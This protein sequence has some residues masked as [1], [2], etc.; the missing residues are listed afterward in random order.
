M[1]RNGYDVFLFC[2]QFPVTPE[3]IPLK[4]KGKNKTMTLINDGEIN[5]LK[6][7]GLTDVDLEFLLP[8]QPGYPFAVYP[9]GFK[10]PDY[11]MGLAE[12]CMTGLET[13]QLIISRSLPDG[14]LL[15]DTNLKVSVED[16]DLDESHG[17]GFDV[18]LRIKLKKYRDFSTKT[19]KLK[20]APGKK[21]EVRVTKSRASSSAK[22]PKKKTVKA[23]KQDTPLS[24]AREK[25]GSNDTSKVHVG[26][27][28]AYDPIKGM[29]TGST[30]HISSSGGTHGGGGGTF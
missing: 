13:T 11:Y 10:R 22:K 5:F 1:S 4:I 21:P 6:M 19:M 7:P 29:S 3:K 23:T 15:F 9:D 28:F 18:I 24:L 16:Y 8:M 12:K 20:P 30:V 2:E 26:G 14:T 25:T 17:E 27:K